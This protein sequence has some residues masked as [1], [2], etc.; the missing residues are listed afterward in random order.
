MAISSLGVGS[1]LNLSGIITSLMQVE[2]QPM[3]ALQKKQASVQTRISALG[4]LSDT[5]T[6][7]QTAAKGLIPS[8][9]QTAGDKFTSFKATSSDSSAATVTASAGAM[10]SSYTLKNITLATAEQVRKDQSA[11]SIPGSG[12]GTLSIK[13]GSGTSVDVSVTGA[14]SLSDIAKAINSAKADVTASVI[15]DGTTNHLI[16]SA[17]NTGASNTISITGSA[18]WEGF[19]YK[20]TTATGDINSWTQQQGAV[21]AS[22]DVNGLTVHSESNTLGSSTIPGLT[23]NLLKESATGT[24]LSITQDSTSSI[25][26]ALN[27]FIKAYNDAVTSM[28]NLGAYNETTKVGAALQGDSTLRSAQS[29]VVGF[30][31][32]PQGSG[33]Y[34]AL[35]DLGVS[36][37]KDGTLK[38]DAGTST[39]T[40]KLTKAIETDF[41]AV[42]NLVSSVGSAFS[43]GL[44][45]LIGSSGSINSVQESAKERIKA[46]ERQQEAL[47]LRLDRVEARYT[48]QFSA[49]DTLVS[50]MNQTGAS[51]TA[52]LADLT[53]S[54]SKS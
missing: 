20:P 31:L 23:I 34:K 1:G 52:M 29:Q 47:Q 32:T 16:I 4:T 8:D 40:N 7:L 33:P 39:T 14:S 11:L 26:A 35:A 24:T 12:T 18:G 54:T 41:S 43:S 44:E 2:Q 51:L 27:S 50:N 19:N 10:V 25:T 53:A 22:V 13:V 15:N 46:L 9:A 42:A 48:K 30:L 21:S 36:L 45:Q 49:L 37:Q 3:I 38:L 28:K 6:A 17:K 5:L